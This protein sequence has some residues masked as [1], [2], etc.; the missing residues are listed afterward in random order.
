MHVLW[1]PSW[2]PT[3]EAP[4]N[5]HF[6]KEAIEV[7]RE[8]GHDVGVYWLEVKNTWK[9]RRTPVQ[10]DETQKLI[11]DSFPNVP[12]GVF[13]GDLI[14]VRKHALKAARAY[15]RRWGKPDVIHAQSVFP[16]I[17][18]AQVLAEY[19]GVPYGITE[20]RE[21]TLYHPEDTPRFKLVQSAVQQADFRFG[22]SSNFAQELEKKYG[23]PFD[24]S[25]LP[26]PDSFFN[27]PIHV[28][29]QPSGTPTRF[30][31]ISSLERR[32]RVEETIL[33]LKAVREMGENVSLD[34]I[35]GTDERI[36]ELKQFVSDNEVSGSVNVLGRIARS[37]LPEILSNYDVFVMVSSIETA[38]MV[39]AESQALGVPVIA[40][41][42]LGGAYMV[43]EETG[44]LVPVDDHDAL[45]EAMV[46]Y[47]RG[48]ISKD[49]ETVRQVAKGRF[50]GDA[51]AKVQEHAYRTA[52]GE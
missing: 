24:I 15:E 37:D 5:G 39:F 27:R 47:S 17:L 42:S 16:G 30:V 18:V 8:A 2:Y 10:V 35:G 25:T 34:V 7:L 49:P 4:L 3:P 46:G 1:T 14:L 51:Y 29:D 28:N 50:S 45:V 13:G 12:R 38:G 20:H 44:V 48:T 52:I 40:S 23:A 9:W 43:Q 33:A 36:E 6:F 32:K 21:S 22:V 26:V 11:Y 31:H 41:A 19:W